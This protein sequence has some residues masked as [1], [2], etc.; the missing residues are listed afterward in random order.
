[1]SVRHALLV[2][3]YCF[4]IAACG[5]SPAFLDAPAGDAA[6][7]ADAS[8]ALGPL[9]RFAVVG[10][11]RPSNEDDLAGYPTAVITKIWADVEAS[12]PHPDF[13][14]STGDYMFAGPNTVP[15]TV[16]K[17]LDLYLGARAQFTNATFPV[18]G[19][20]E[21]TGATAS[22]CGAGARDGITLN[23]AEFMRR[24]LIPH[25]I[26]TPYYAIAFAASDDS[27]TMKLVFVAGNA[28][29]DTQAAWLDGAL[30]AP[31]TYTFVVRHESS[32]VNNAPGVVPSE[33]ILA[34]YPVTLR[35]VGHTHTYA[36][37]ATRHEVICGNGG[38]PLSSGFGFG[39]A[40]IER[41]ASGAI[42]LTERDSTTNAVV[43]QFRLNADGSPA[44]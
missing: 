5:N 28:W 29:S 30:A 35:I 44:P 40:I 32:I 20:H 6:P 41:L 14:I 36:H 23:Y 37:Y 9:F 3:A 7:E 21:C 22:N 39:Y 15:S 12:S 4:G 2:S 1:M 38:A 27:W 16:D 11:T 34:R 25:G 17:Q 42:Q 24:M 43:D 18:I 19:N 31:T 10:D 26:T 8:T 33:A 13:A